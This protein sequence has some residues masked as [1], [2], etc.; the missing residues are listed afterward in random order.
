MQAE[1]RID[2]GDFDVAREWQACRTR[3]AGRAGAVVAF[4]GIVRDHAGGDEVN[5]LYL[6]HYP[7]M[8]EASIERILATASDRWDL[9]DTVVIH[10]VGE[11]AP[12]DQIVLVLVA[13]AH[14]GDAFAACEYIMDYLKTDAVFWKK[15]RRS[16]G[17]SWIR[18]TAGDHERRNGWQGNDG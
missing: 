8:T 6:E 4:A 3:L 10:R 16:T 2:T 1:I 17:A 14:R 13:A 18:A 5:G 12:Q 11:L 15:E 9:I 7:G